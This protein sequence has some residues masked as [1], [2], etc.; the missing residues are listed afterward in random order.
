M[1]PKRLKKLR[2]SKKLSQQTMADFLGISRQGYGKYE[3]GKSQPDHQTL[4]KLAEY[5]N[6]TVDFLLG[7]TDIPHRDEESKRDA[8]IYKIA[9]EFPDADLM[10][11]DIES[12]SAKDFEDLYDYIKFKNSQKEKRD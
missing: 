1:L 12:W 10:F 4:V 2:N 3:D 9:T 5:F 7:R 8:I 6:V 11:K